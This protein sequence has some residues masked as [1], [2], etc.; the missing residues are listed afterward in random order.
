V[1][2]PN[3]KCAGQYI[4]VPLRFAWSITGRPAQSGAA[5]TQTTTTTPHLV[6]DRP[7]PWQV[8]FT[9]C[10]N[11]CTVASLNA[12]VP[13]ISRTV[14]F[15]AVHGVEGHISS[16]QLDSTLKL[17]LAGSRVQISQTGAGQTVAGSQSFIDFGAT[18]EQ[19]GAP[20]AIPFSI[21]PPV[22]DVSTTDQAI[23]LASQGAVAVVAGTDIDQVRVRANDVHLDLSNLGKWSAGVTGGGVHLGL[24]FDS[25]HPAVKCEAHYT[26]KSLFLVTLDEGWS[27][28]LCPDFDLSQMNLSLTLLPTVAN[29]QVAIS[30]NQ[31]DAQLVPGSDTQTDLVNLF[32]SATDDLQTGIDTKLHSQLAD[33]AVKAGIAQLL[34]GV[35]KQRFS[36]LGPIVGMQVNDNDWVIRYQSTTGLPTC[37]PTC[38]GQNK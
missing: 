24:A 5:L 12:T 33:P 15:T 38:V 17:L 26:V 30:G 21:D 3:P 31:V 22:E 28:D 10:P 25:E 7:G 32:T 34:N 29:G 6:P 9:A 37:V 2:L 20:A 11:T 27:D 16:D 4:T 13:P 14:N 18:A 36:D 23:L 1:K 8:T 19:N 35:L